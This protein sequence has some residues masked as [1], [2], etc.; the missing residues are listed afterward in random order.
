VDPRCNPGLGD[1]LFAE[2]ALRHL[3]QVTGEPVR[4]YIEGFSKPLFRGRDDF[5][6]VEEMDSAPWIQGS[7]YNAYHWSFPRRRHW[8]DGYYEQFGLNADDFP[9]SERRPILAGYPM[10]QER[11]RGDYVVFCPFSMS[12]PSVLFPGSPRQKMALPSFWERVSY[13]IDVPCVCLGHSGAPTIPN[14]LAVYG[15]DLRTA[16]AIMRS[17]RVVVTVPTGLLPLSAAC[18]CDI[19][20]L[21]SE[22]EPAWFICPQSRGRVAI[23]HAGIPSNWDIS[24]VVERD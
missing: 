21:I 22:A 19:I 16:A 12:C 7:C 18:D 4:L 10:D 14:T 20:A 9:Q 17:A 13:G 15:E 1:V 6:V 8:V 11:V 24:D 5:E 3:A 23:R 2:P